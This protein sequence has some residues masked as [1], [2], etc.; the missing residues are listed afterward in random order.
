MRAPQVIS[1]TIN[2]YRSQWFCNLTIAAQD[3]SVAQSFTD[4]AHLCP[5]NCCPENCNR[6]LEI[7]DERDHGQGSLCNIQLDESASC[8]RPLLRTNCLPCWLDEAMALSIVCQTTL[9][10]DTA[11]QSMTDATPSICPIAV[12]TKYQLY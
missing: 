12:S 4:L 1:I 8:D 11:F 3:D 10:H 6:V 9:H 2:L 5:E 7:S